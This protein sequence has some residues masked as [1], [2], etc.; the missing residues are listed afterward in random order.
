MSYYQGDHIINVT[1]KGAAQ[2]SFVS[3]SF[4]AK[5]TTQAD[6]GPAAKDQA[7]GRI[8]A[9]LETINRFADSAKVEKDRLRTTFS[10]DAV[11]DY[12][13][14][15]EFKGYQAVYSVNFEVNNVAQ[16]TALHDALTSIQGVESPT[17][18]YNVNKSHEFAAQAFANAIQNAA[19]TFAGQCKALGLNPS[20]YE[21]TSWTVQDDHRGGGK[22]NAI[23]AV[24][25]GPV[26]IEPGRAL[27]EVV[28]SVFYKRK[29]A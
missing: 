8:Q 24:D 29:A 17:P 15:N 7:K 11:R 26:E 1:A 16:A 14:N 6:T 12:Q 25:A 2:T 9:I 27:L 3:A 28:V 20:D 10:V 22:F 21:V 13:R 4:R 18:V 23:L 19:T 5:V